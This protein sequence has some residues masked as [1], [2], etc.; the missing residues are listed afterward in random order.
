[1][2]CARCSIEAVIVQG[3]QY[4]CEKHYR[5]G[6]MRANAKRDS[7]VAPTHEQL[8]LMITNQMLC[9][10]CGVV[11]NWR[12]KDGRSTVASL[13]HY[14]SGRMA[15]VC[16]S[17]NTRHASMDG[18]SYC[19]MPKDHKQCPSCKTIKHQSSFAVDNGRSGLIKRKSICKK[20][21]DI[22]VQQWKERNKDEYN[23]YQRA[24]RAKR[25]A[26]GRPITR[27]DQFA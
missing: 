4:L 16:L 2:K 15:I 9:P 23:A 18:D 12:S 17:C 14:R 25:K 6:Q 27:N 24:Y 13:Q 8:E 7:K 11:M 19:D 22:K 21:S 3:R 1:M 20:C 5:F 26:E 10:D